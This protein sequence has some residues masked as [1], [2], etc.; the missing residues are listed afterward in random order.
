MAFSPQKKAPGDLIKSSE[1]N[2]AL[3]EVARLD[4]AKLD[5]AGGAISGPLSVAA[6]LGV[7]TASPDRALTVQGAAGTYLN[8]KANGGTF[9]VLVGAD[10]N[11]GILS[12]M[13][14]H[15]L[16][17]RSGG[18]QTR[19]TIKADGKVAIGTNAPGFLLDVA[20]RVRFRQ[21]PA[22]TAGLWFY[23]TAPNA[24]RAFVGMLDD[25]SVGFW[26]QGFG[27]G[28]SMNISSG[29]VTVQ[30]PLQ[31]NG[32]LGAFSGA[33]ADEWPKVTWYRDPANHWDEGLLKHTSAKGRF[34]R[35]GYAIHFDSSRE[36]GLW[37][38]GWD[39]LLAVEGGS[40][41]TV[42][43]GNLMVGIGNPQQ[44]KVGYAKGPYGCDSIR[45]EP[46]LWLD[47]AGTVILKTGFTSNGMDVAERFRTTGPV[48]PGQVLV[49][50]EFENAARL[51]DRE[52]DQRVVGIV[53]TAPACI[54]GMDQQEAPVALCGRAPCLV[55]ADIAPIAA[56]DLLTTS[57]TRG[58]A[59]KAMEP[60]R[61]VGA[62]LGK[63]MGSLDAGK[64]KILV[65]V[66]MQ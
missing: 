57:P 49:F 39:P 25:N 8:V 40:G 53:S 63:A 11:G 9:E 60:A 5:K 7:G 55:D 66:V 48:E 6:A 28:F 54:L 20:D 45:G 51:C 30:G 23:Q 41:N 18:N 56:G 36:F 46:N 42:L 2:D 26:G 31:V 10:S 27:W 65:M 33:D 1:W 62:I 3:T 37:S 15:D 29:A 34:K 43:K 35:A 17:L 12:T 19:L 50:D 58:H 22:G 52:A 4:T 24:D 59:Q 38:T 14:N 64:G 61:A 13:T 21:G 44:V 32:S 16:Q 47:A